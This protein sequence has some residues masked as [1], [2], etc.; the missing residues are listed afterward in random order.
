MY[1]YFLNSLF[2][3]FFIISSVFGTQ[4]D[5]LKTSDINKIMQQIF[6]QHV[7]QKEIS[8]SIIQN[9][10]KNYLD[11]FDPERFYLLESEAS[12]YLRLPQDRLLTIE[13][14]YEKGHYPVYEDLNQLFQKAISRSRSYRAVLE[15][16]NE[17]LF[18][19]AKQLKAR[20]TPSQTFADS[21]KELKQRLRN[22]MVSFLRDEIHRYGAENIEKNLAEVLAVYEKAQR[23]FE[24][25]YNYRSNSGE[26]LSDAQR[27]NLFS[28]HVLKALAKSLD[29]HT[30]IYNPEEAYDMKVRLEKGFEGIGVVFQKDGDGIIISNIVKNGPAAKSGQIL[31]KDEVIEVNGI[32]IKDM[33]FD[34]LIEQVRTHD[35]ITL[36]LSRKV[37]NADTSQVTVTL[38]REPIMMDEGR[39]EVSHENFG[40]GIIGKITLHSFYQNDQGIT[41]E[42]DVRDAIEQLDREGNL[43]GLVLDLRENSGG[44]L[45]QAVKVAGLFIT[46]GV[47]V[48][49]KYANG[50]E[51]LYRDMDGSTAY[52]GPLLVL[53]SRATASAAEIVAQALQDYGVALVVGDDQTY[54]KGTIQS[55]TVTDKE[56]A[57]SYFKVTVGK[58]YTPSGKTPQLHGV[59]ADI[60]VPGPFA[61][62]QIG[63]EYL[64][65]AIRQDDQIPAVFSDKL[66]DIDPSLRNWYLKYYMPSLQHQTLIWKELSP[67][68]SK[69]SA[70]RIAHNKNYQ[71]FFKRL[72]EKGTALDVE[73]EESGIAKNFGSGDLQM[74]EAV[75]IIKDMIYLQS[76]VRHNEYM[77]GSEEPFPKLAK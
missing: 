47:V 53:T 73:D 26:M 3:S 37:K 25:G 34:K 12:T 60:V 57:A 31:V 77:V 14:E 61:K 63:E 22:S 45:S 8:I 10:I 28:L 23:S 15:L 13:R 24:D 59:K 7:D 70:W 33:P 11:Q 64:E 38:K 54:G 71:L 48:I 39:V 6:S 20:I 36:V 9:S 67:I 27:E 40:N 69:N 49:S 56:S 29:A 41:S 1:K 42:K 19:E 16:E 35:S 18:K 21:E 2:F 17:A 44:F 62:A 46:N 58:Y 76:K 32:P 75:N 74:A 5:L 50:E 66:A 68:L 43:R 55:Q 52:N 30:T 51:K 65:Y 4:A 72:D